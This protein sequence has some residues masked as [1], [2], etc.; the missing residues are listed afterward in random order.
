MTADTTGVPTRVVQYSFA[1]ARP[2]AAA[3][4]RWTPES[5]VTLTVLDPVE[6][7]IAQRYYDKGVFFEAEDR[8]VPPAEGPA[9][10]RALVQPSRSSYTRFVDESEQTEG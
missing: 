8:V 10:M 6:G 9:F 4:F 7:E 2:E 3:E 5:G 1:T